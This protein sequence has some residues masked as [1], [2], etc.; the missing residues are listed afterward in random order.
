MELGSTLR[1][2]ADRLGGQFV[3][4]KVQSLELEGP[5]KL[6]RTRKNEYRTKT[7]V[8]AMGAGHRKL[9]APGEEE[10]GGMGV[11]YCA[12]CDGAFFG[13]R[14]PPWPAAGMWRRRMPFFWPEAAERYI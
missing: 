10:F 6:V 11:S 14:W 13:I 2:H 1:D 3:R 9:G 8:L 12:T 7:V 5:V 4:E